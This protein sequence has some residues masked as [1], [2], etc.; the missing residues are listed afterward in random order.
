MIGAFGAHR[1]EPTSSPGVRVGQN[2]LVMRRLGREIA[3]AGFDI[4]VVQLHRN[5]AGGRWLLVA[6]SQVEERC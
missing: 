6:G 5:E 4:G 3:D 2:N 1:R